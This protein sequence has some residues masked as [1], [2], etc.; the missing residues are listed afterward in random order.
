[1]D[2]YNTNDN[3]SKTQEIM[4]RCKHCK[5]KFEPTRFN[6]KYCFN[7]ECVKVWVDTEKTKQWK[8]KKTQLKK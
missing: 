4:P 8:A 7:T 1:M 3:K 2:K 6:Q 5:E